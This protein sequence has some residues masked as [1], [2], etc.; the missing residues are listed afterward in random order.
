M[1]VSDLSRRHGAEAFIAKPFTVLDMEWLI[2]ELSPCAPPL[3]ISCDLWGH[4]RMPRKRA[5]RRQAR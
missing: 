3:P 2:D 4:P 5:F 1:R